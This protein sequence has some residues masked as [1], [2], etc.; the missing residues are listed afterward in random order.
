LTEAQYTFLFGC[1]RGRVD[2][3]SI[4]S[5]SRHVSAGGQGEV[6]GIASHPGGQG[7]DC[8]SH[9]TSD[10][11]QTTPCY[12][13]ASNMPGNYSRSFYIWDIFIVVYSLLPRFNSH[14]IEWCTEM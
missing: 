14:S 10:P 9:Q 12:P 3:G 13:P 11:I 5:P 7:S 8:T 2:N 4:V 6:V 1:W